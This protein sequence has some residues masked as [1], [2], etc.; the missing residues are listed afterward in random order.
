M[1]TDFP[2]EAAFEYV[3]LGDDIAAIEFRDVSVS[4]SDTLCQVVAFAA[5]YCS[6]RWAWRMLVSLSVFRWC[7]I[8]SI[9]ANPEAQ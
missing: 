3:G 2:N 8:F 6:C 1:G 7:R 4:L 5:G 9:V